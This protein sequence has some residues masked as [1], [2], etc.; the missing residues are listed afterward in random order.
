MADV[1]EESANPASLEPSLAKAKPSVISNQDIS[2]ILTGIFGGLYSAEVIG[3]DMAA[4]LDRS[5]GGP[6]P[7]HQRYVQ[8]LRKLHEQYKQRMDEADVLERHVIEARARA[9]A[10]QEVAESHDS[11]GGLIPA[12]ARLRYC[13]DSDLLRKHKLISPA[14]YHV[15]PAPLTRA[16]RAR[17]TP[18]FM[19]ET[20]AFSKR[21]SNSP[22]DGVYSDDTTPRQKPAAIAQSLSEQSLT[23]LSSEPEGRRR[24]QKP[25]S[26]SQWLGE[27][28]KRQQGSQAVEREQ[29]RQKPEAA[30]RTGPQNFLLNPRHLPPE[31]SRSGRSLI[32]QRHQSSSPENLVPLFIANPPV[33]L[34]TDFVVGQMYE[35]TVELRNVTSVSRHLRVLP[36]STPYFSIGLGRFPSESGCVAPGM[37]CSYSVRFA[38]DSLA[39]VDDFLLVE[40][41]AEHT[42]LVPIQAR[43]PPPILTLPPVLNVGPCLVGGGKV[44]EFLCHN[45]G[46]GGGRFCVMPRHRWPATNFRSVVS[47]GA[48]SLPPFEVQPVF[49]ELLP[50]EATILEVTFSPTTLGTFT[51]EF[52]VVCDNCQVKHFTIAGEGQVAGVQLTWVEGG[53]AEP[54]LGELTDAMAHV[55]LR[56]GPL[57]P[58]GSASKQIVVQ[59]TADV[60]LPFSWRVVKPNLRAPASPDDAVGAVEPAELEYHLHAHSG[61]SV[62]PEHGTLEPHGQHT[63]TISFG[64]TKPKRYHSVLHLVLSDVPEIP[65]TQQPSTVHAAQGQGVTD[66][67]VLEVEVKG[68]SEPFRVLLEP[69]AVCLPGD[70]YVGHP[71]YRPFQLRNVSAA[72][73]RFHWD[74]MMEPHQVEVKPS[75]GEVE[76][77]GS[78]CCEVCV[79]GKAPGRL[80]HAL[81]CHIKHQQEPIALHI[82]ATFKGPELLV[83]TPTLDLGLVRLGDSAE[84]RLRLRN[85][86]QVPVRWR[87]A[88]APAGLVAAPGCGEL[89]PRARSEAVLTFRPE[90][91]LTLQAHMELQVEGGESRPVMLCAEVQSPRVCL[92]NSGLQLS[93]VYLGVVVTETVSLLNQT[94]LATTYSW[95]QLCG[96][97][98]QSC[99]VRATPAS[100]SIGPREKVDVSVEFTALTMDEL[101]D[102][103]LPCSVAGMDEPLLLLVQARAQ[104]LHVTFSTPGSG[105]SAPNAATGISSVQIPSE[106]LLLDFGSEVRLGDFVTR[107]LVMTNQTAI[108]AA[109]NVRVEYFSG[110]PPPTP[111]GLA[112]RCTRMDSSLLLTKALNKASVARK[113]PSKRQAEV[114]EAALLAGRGAAFTC[115]PSAGTLGAFSRQEVAVTAVSDM[116]G[117]YRDRL[118]CQVGD[119][120]PVEVPVRMSV[121]GCPLHLQLTG[122]LKDPS[123]RPIVRFGTHVSGGDTVSRSLRINNTSPFAVRVDWES[124]NVESQDGRLLD[125]LLCYGQPFPLRDADGNELLATEAAVPSERRGPMPWVERFTLDEEDDISVP[126]SPESLEKD[127]VEGA[128]ARRDIIKVRLREHEGM[129][130]DFPYCITPSQMVVPARGHATV[131]VS[132][133][134]LL[135][136]DIE[137]RAECAGF[138]LGYLSLDQQ[139]VVCVPEKVDRPHGYEVPPLRVD[140]QAFV[141]QAM[142]TVQMDVDEGDRG[143]KFHAEAS[144]LIKDGKVE[145]ESVQTQ[146]MALR[147]EVGAALSF[148]LQTSGNFALLQPALPG[149]QSPAARPQHTTPSDGGESADTITLMPQHSLQVEV[150]FQ[151]SPELL[152]ERRGGDLTLH[153]QGQLTVHYS[154]RTQQS[155]PLEAFVYMPCL[156][157]RVP[158]GALHFG[159]C[160]VGQRRARL[161]TIVNRGAAR[162]HWSA[163]VQSESG[164]ENGSFE[165]SPRNGTLAPH[166]STQLHVSFTARKPAESHAEL[167]VLGLLGEQ[168]PSIGLSGSGSFDGKHEALRNT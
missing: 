136:T 52:T 1:V 38:P 101:R 99:S 131:G 116:W 124:Y 15:E 97:Q 10:D 37:S 118:L 95:G 74:Q 30:G 92:L 121:H 98:A 133:T 104:G 123:T 51:Q 86:G 88:A 150:G 148:R 3:R 168:P 9:A 36:P 159:P 80:A 75:E 83:E 33:V 60:G 25:R 46:P 154:N 54:A 21:V 48:V 102:L 112:A 93:E 62:S 82:Q 12:P 17:A 125:L 79:V 158:E 34:F 49:F 90:R 7:Y 11:T 8:K 117:H 42:L 67:I 108:E 166:G 19:A 162:G 120:K 161:A 22:V 61:F 143:L 140:L 151:L 110:A 58:F 114:R 57:H 78:V 144:D 35:T 164:E 105:A 96:P 4:S 122:L 160:L 69:P 24:P 141:R 50:G 28:G 111:S 44:V 68:E 40:T 153:V 147:N 70:V 91:C 63:F 103:V 106:E 66:V 128:P 149:Q 72:T 77:G 113:P 137:S 87:L 2:H 16:P 138:V 145:M 20:V 39:D 129:E 109:F 127:V 32:A 71:T 163:H 146:R 152:E 31:D 94:L 43:R 85:P 126:S 130:S 139:D 107:T 76:A 73:M 29:E 53:A 81:I 14:D 135:L 89:A 155:V 142:L 47:V 64:P 27:V 26:K 55:L 84:A 119:L 167:C 165:V 41:Q 65:T 156:E 157:L 56:L 100:G 115:E 18:H 45:A 23:T 5:A 59:S 132:F 134:P 6:K 13:A